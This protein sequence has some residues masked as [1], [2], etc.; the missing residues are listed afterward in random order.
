LFWKTTD[1]RTDDLP[2]SKEESKTGHLT[3][4][5]RHVKAELLAAIRRDRKEKK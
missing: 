5:T 3:A 2:L 1:P 4:R